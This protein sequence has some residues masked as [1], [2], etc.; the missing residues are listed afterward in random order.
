MLNGDRNAF[1]AKGPIIAGK[2]CMFLNDETKNDKSY[3]MNLRTRQ[4]AEGE[5][6]SICIAESKMGKT[7]MEGGR[8]EKRQRDRQSDE[9]CLAVFN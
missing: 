6:Y 3:C 7:S 2:K 1:H 5:T 8:Q 4:D 9:F